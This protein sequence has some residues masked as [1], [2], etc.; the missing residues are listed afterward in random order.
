[1]RQLRRLIVTESVLTRGQHVVRIEDA[2][3]AFG[4]IIHADQRSDHPAGRLRIR[5]DGQP[6]IQRAT[7]V[8]LKVAPT[9][10]AQ[11]RRIE[12][13]GDPLKHLGKHAP[14]A[15]VEEQRLVIL[16]QEMIEAEIDLRIEDGDAVNVGSDFGNVGHR[17]LGPQ[18][19]VK[20]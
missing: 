18:I 11:H 19:R 10:P 13:L 14:Q 9:D 5:R 2:G 20:L 3:F 17:N 12:H 15:G 1:M 8:R 6:I 4:K 16:H 7:L